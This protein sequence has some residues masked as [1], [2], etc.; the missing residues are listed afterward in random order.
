MQGCLKILVC[1]EIEAEG[2]MRSILQV[3]GVL[4]AAGTLQGCGGTAG[5]GDPGA[6][7]LTAGQSCKNIQ[8]EL[9]RL[10][11]RGVQSAI[12]R[13]QSGSKLSGS[14]KA[15]ADRYNSL[16]NEYLGARCHV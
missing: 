10:I 9:D 1:A 12:E 6:R 8:V 5:A 15:D 4:L 11:G 3:V 14:Q 16:L 13:Q 7:S 2:G